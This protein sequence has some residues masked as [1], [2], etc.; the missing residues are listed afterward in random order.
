[1]DYRFKINNNFL[2]FKDF[3]LNIKEFFNK[4]NTTIHKARNEIKIIKYNNKKYVVKSFKKP[5]L[6]KSIYYTKT[7]S[8]AKRSYEYSL[9][10]GNLTPTPIGYIEFFEKNRLSDSFF[11]SEYFEYDF[12][13]REVLFNKNFLDRE[14]ILKEFAKFTSKL[15]NKNIL[16]LDY[17]AGNILIKKEANKYKFKVV[18]VNRMKFKKLSIDERLKNFNMLWASNDDMKIIITEYA[19]INNI[20]KNYAIN[21]AISYSFRLKLFKNFKKL[22]KGKIKNIDW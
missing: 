20:N 17:S 5:T 14:V 18:D 12:L 21:K 1:M 15:H 2:E 8:K 4:N 9:I 19:R 16:H 7:S 13:I 11:I 6:L 10:L 3:L 22:I